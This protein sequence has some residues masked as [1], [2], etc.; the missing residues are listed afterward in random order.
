MDHKDIHA[1]YV[2]LLK[3]HNEAA[4]KLL[5]NTTAAM[6]IIQDDCGKLGHLMQDHRTPFG[7]DTC[8]GVCK[9]RESNDAVPHAPSVQT[10]Q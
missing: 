5:N 4:D 10:L 8:C 9:F 3:E 1:R 2:A 6:K 7:S